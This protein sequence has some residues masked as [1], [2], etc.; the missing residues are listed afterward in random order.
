MHKVVAKITGVLYRATGAGADL[1]L[2]QHDRELA[3][4]LARSG[5]RLTDSL[6]FESV[7]RLLNESRNFIAR[8]D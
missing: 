4:L 1:R 8:G 3:R 6:E 2:K 7:Q 5:G